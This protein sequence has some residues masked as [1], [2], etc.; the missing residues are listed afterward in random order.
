[1]IG[2]AVQSVS[3]MQYDILQ[4]SSLVELALSGQ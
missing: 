4:R 1:M 3:A 2:C